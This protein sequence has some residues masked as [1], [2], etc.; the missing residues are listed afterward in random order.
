MR[1]GK[2]RMKKNNKNIL[3][4][5]AGVLLH[6]TSLPGNHGVGDLGQAAYDFIDFLSSAGQRYWQVL[7]IGPGDMIFACSPYMSLAA[8]AGNPL[9]ISP[10]LLVAD[11][12]LSSKDLQDKPDFSEYFVEF[13]KVIPY[14]KRLLQKA[15]ENF[16][17]D[18]PFVDFE[19]FS[20]NKQWLS[21]Y[22][23][24]MSLREQFVDMAWNAWP[25]ELVA[26]EPAALAQW[27]QK[28]SDRVNF[29]KFEQFC[30][31]RQWQKMRDYANSKGVRLIGDIPIYVSLD[32]VDVWANQECFCL[33]E[34][35]RQPT[36]VAGVPPDYFSET[37]QRWGNPLYRWKIGTQKNARLYGWWRTRFHQLRSVV[38]LVRI[39]HFRAFESYWQVSASEKTAINGKW[40][41]GPGRYFFQA[42][43]DALHDL[44]VI[45]EDL[46]IITPE[47]E[48]LREELGFP[49]MKILQFAFDSDEENLYLPHNYTDSN[50]VVF[51]GTHDNNTT[52]GWF[53][54]AEGSAAGK[55]R[56][57]RYANSDGSNISWDFIRLAM[58]SV[59]DTA[60]IPLQ[61]VLGFGADCRF[62]LPGS[63]EGNW[64]WR[65]AA[66]F[67]NAGV[68]ARLRDE[69]HF[70]GRC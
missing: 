59:A 7:P 53:L 30:F 47:V 39:D 32:S 66:R 43:G 23:L 68:A 4:R 34:I 48:A 65:C 38:D 44:P 11:G 63:V 16:Q 24:F 51:T 57:M 69:T 2:A 36:H 54:G 40:V 61:D 31:S 10:E 18:L 41:K 70:Y 64:V 67:L 58:A 50:C 17:R 27:T 56:A 33:D 46:G 19:K 55:E 21:D 9:L 42:M 8:L 45:A 5:A 29:Y 37:G 15:F 60:I 52:L 49:G 6:V 25:P 13:D 28:L 22:A 14:K 26:R 3:E 20:S 62:N 35:S 12:Y 1:F